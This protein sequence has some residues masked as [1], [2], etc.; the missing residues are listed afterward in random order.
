MHSEVLILEN[1]F[2]SNYDTKQQKNL[3]DL[4]EYRKRESLKTVILAKKHPKEL[5]N[6][7]QKLADFLQFGIVYQ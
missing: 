1:F 5:D 2:P 7:D 6:I 3:I 4:I